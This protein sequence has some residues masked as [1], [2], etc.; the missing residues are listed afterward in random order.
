V[1]ERASAADD[2]REQMLRAAIQVIGERGFA[3]T[4]IADVGRR[5]G[6]SSALVIYY[7]GTKDQLL[8]EALRY[9]EDLFY[10]EAAGL[11]DTIPDAKGKLEALIRFSC[12]D[13][14]IQDLPGSWVLWLDL[15]TQAVRH[16]EVAR[17]RELLDQRWRDQITTVVRLGQTTGEFLDV[18]A[19]DFAITLSALL[20]GLA[21]QV[22][23]KDPTIT[24]D[25]A[26]DV[27]LHTASRE[28]GVSWDLPSKPRRALGRT[29][30]GAVPGPAPSP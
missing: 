14:S 11:L 3:D 9:C 2:R 17:D 25:R 1:S 30:P 8:T 6:A 20:D 24:P 10:E 28:L 15:W 29:R 27:C 13:E 18:D 5:A 23:L 26:I 16:P 21:V 4:R 12:T 19:E 22:A 7:F